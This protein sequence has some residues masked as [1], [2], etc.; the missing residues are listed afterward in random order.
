MSP[1]RL[2]LGPHL[3]PPFVLG[4]DLACP[5]TRTDCTWLQG[6]QTAPNGR[7]QSPTAFGYFPTAP[8]SPNGPQR[9]RFHLDSDLNQSS[10]G[11]G[12]VLAGPPEEAVL[13]AAGSMSK[14]LTREE[15]LAGRCGLR[16]RRV[17]YPGEV[18]EKAATLGPSAFMQGEAGVITGGR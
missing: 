13:K 2:L 14:G 11:V 16:I 15:G 12:Q 5:R 6:L 17:Q 18:P 8:V 4:A 10:G 3:L 1:Q 7:G 9:P